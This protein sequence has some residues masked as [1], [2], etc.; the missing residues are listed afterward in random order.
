MRHRELYMEK[1]ETG[2]TVFVVL[3]GATK[4]HKAEVRL[5]QQHP[6]KI[7][8]TKNE[9]HDD[10]DLIVPMKNLLKRTWELTK[11]NSKK[12]IEDD[13]K[14]FFKKL[15]RYK[16]EERKNPLENNK[17]K[18]DDIC[19]SQQSIAQ[20]KKGKSINNF[21]ETKKEEYNLEP[22]AESQ[23]DDNINEN[24]GNSETIVD[25]LEKNNGI[26]NN[27]N[28]MGEYKSKTIDSE[29]RDN[30]EKYSTNREEDDDKNKSDDNENKKD[31]YD[32]ESVDNIEDNNNEDNEDYNENNNE[33]NEDNEN[34]I[35]GNNEDNENIYEDNNKDNKEY[36]TSKEE[37]N[38]KSRKDNQNKDN[39]IKDKKDE[40]EDKSINDIKSDNNESKEENNNMSKEYEESFNDV[41][42]DYDED[43]NKSEINHEGNSM[44]ERSNES[45]KEETEEKTDKD[46]I[47]ENHIDEKENSELPNVNGKQLFEG[48]MNVDGKTFNV[49]YIANDDGQTSIITQNEETKARKEIF[50]P[51]DTLK[52]VFRYKPKNVV[53]QS[54]N[55]LSKFAII[56]DDILDL[57]LDKMERYNKIK[58]EEKKV[59]IIQRY[60][61]EWH[62]KKQHNENLR[63]EESKNEI[64]MLKGVKLDNGEYAMMKIS[65]NTE[66]NEIGR[67]HV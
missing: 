66:D 36:A 57:N 18:S 1:G 19:E 26:R 45:K 52:Y 56:K 64:L 23:Y 21:E 2:Y 61:K 54:I 53:P 22:N 27:I 40:D 17:F 58:L 48:N 39:E 24:S 59:R 15:Q 49:K 8:Y 41:E 65:L 4:E 11:I 30:N 29:K 3:R 42:K 46:K 37:D 9:I 7:I 32:S 10:F 25:D 16:K 43:N 38:D 67:A 44:A 60:C 13:V 35:E 51:N 33:D 63:K 6:Y 62:K 14:C 50:L 34:N 28:E 12:I 31:E 5:I 47:S 55:A 20:Q